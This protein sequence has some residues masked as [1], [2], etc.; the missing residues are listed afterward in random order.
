M[1][2]L[3]RKEQSWYSAHIP[4]FHISTEWETFDELMTHINEAVSLYFEEEKTYVT[5][6]LDT[7]F[8]LDFTNFNAS[9]LQTAP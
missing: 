3:I 9:E 5:T 6:N 4:D 2:I 8:Y 7:S 1:K